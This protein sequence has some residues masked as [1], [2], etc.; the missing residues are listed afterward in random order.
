MK[1]LFEEMMEMPQ[2]LVTPHIAGY[3]WEALYKMSS[4]LLGK[5]VTHE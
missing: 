5:I 1:S 4:S 3:S 2:V